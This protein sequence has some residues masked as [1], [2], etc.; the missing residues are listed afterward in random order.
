MMS[1]DMIDLSCTGA[2]RAIMLEIA[3]NVTP[4][5]RPMATLNLEIFLSLGIGYCQLSPLL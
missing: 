5:Q 1:V 2:H 4:S 3:G